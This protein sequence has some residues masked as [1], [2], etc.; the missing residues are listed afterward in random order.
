MSETKYNNKNIRSSLHFSLY[1]LDN[2][3]EHIRF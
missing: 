3:L 1:I 2:K